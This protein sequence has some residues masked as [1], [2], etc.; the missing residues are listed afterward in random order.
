MFNT[1]ITKVKNFQAKRKLEKHLNR[2][3][4]VTF[5]FKCDKPH[6]RSATKIEEYLYAYRCDGCG[7]QSEFEFGLYPLPILVNRQ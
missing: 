5:C 3:G 1:L 6:L 2:F 4:F 7:G